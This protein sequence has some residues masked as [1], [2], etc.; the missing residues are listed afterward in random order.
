MSIVDKIEA[1]KEKEIP[2]DLMLT[3]IADILKEYGNDKFEL[4][5]ASYIAGYYRAKGEL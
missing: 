2:T 5:S 3:E 1:Q 4:L